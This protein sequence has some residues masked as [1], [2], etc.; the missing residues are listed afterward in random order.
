[1]WATRE[2]VNYLTFAK[3]GRMWGTRSKVNYPTLAKPRLGW[4]TRIYHA[5]LSRAA[6]C[7]SRDTRP[8]NSRMDLVDRLADVLV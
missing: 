7:I 4:G 8:I 6:A 3:S 1:M 5:H 2:K